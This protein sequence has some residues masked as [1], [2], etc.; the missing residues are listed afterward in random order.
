MIPALYKCVRS[1]VSVCEC[2]FICACYFVLVLLVT[3]FIS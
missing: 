1:C 2:V 3:K